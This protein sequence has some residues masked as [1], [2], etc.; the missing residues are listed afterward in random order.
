MKDNKINI[1]KCLSI[2]SLFK[3]ISNTFIS[4]FMPLIILNEVGYKMAI[5][6]VMIL[7]V[8]IILGLTVFY[9]IITKNPVL[10]ICIHIFFAIGSYLIIAIFKVSVLSVVFNAICTGLGQSLYHSS[11]F[12]II[13]ANK[14]K[15]GFSYY[16][17]FSFIG[18]IFM[19]LFNGYIL[20]TEENFSILITCLISLGLY[21]ISI[22]PFLLIKSNLKTK[23]AEIVKLRDGVKLVKPFNIFH[24]SFGLQ[25][26]IVS[27]IIPLF[28]AINNLSIQTIAF[29]VAIVNVVKIIMTIFANYMYK[30]E[31]A[32]WSVVI[33]S[34][35]FAV[36]C[37]ILPSIK[38]QV[39]IYVL[40]VLISIS[41]PL[42]FISDCNIYAEKTKEFSHKAM[43]LREM[44][45]HGFRPI[46]LLPFLF[47]TNLKIMIYFGVVLAVLLIVSCYFFTKKED[48]ISNTL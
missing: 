40:S 5:T 8:S 15:S 37:I 9:K 29:V 32:F 3:S 36:S 41:F 39:F 13:S 44:F 18:S 16:H 35:I 46:I 2:H 30:K 28:L 43:I 11:I 33:G 47:I 45:V 10:A 21:I 4:L 42:F 31:K 14:S 34:L 12:S 6:Y 38:N 7:S 22:I 23:D 20:N 25:D 48:N 17:I 19:I 24:A 1:S 27:L 26:L